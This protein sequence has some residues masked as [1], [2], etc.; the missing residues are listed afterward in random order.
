M[1]EESLGLGV[2]LEGVVPLGKWD[3]SEGAWAWGQ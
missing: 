2:D 3:D 1:L